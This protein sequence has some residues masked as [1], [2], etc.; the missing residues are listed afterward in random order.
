[1]YISKQN[2]KEKTKDNIYEACDAWF[3]VNTIDDIINY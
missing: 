2:G 1:M 3:G